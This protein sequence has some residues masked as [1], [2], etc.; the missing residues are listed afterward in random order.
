MDV[1]GGENKIRCCKEQYCKETWN[2]RSTNHGKLDVVK[3]KEAR[4]NT[5]ILAIG[6]L[7]QTRMG[8]FNL[9]NHHI[10]Y[11]GQEFFGRNGVPF[12]I[13]ESVK[14]NTWVQSQK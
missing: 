9:D 10:Y 6:E 2:V 3:Q 13:N 11:C 4:V 1:S 7:I 5:D 8:E 14:C 12:I